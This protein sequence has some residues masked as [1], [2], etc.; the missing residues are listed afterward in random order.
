MRIPLRGP[1]VALESDR[2]EDGD[3]IGTVCKRTQAATEK[4]GHSHESRIV[5][6]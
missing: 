5:R 6:E 4:I 1:H 2:R 3:C